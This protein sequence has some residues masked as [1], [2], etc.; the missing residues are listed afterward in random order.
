MWVGVPKRKTGRDPDPGAHS[1]S[2]N[3]SRSDAL[4]LADRRSVKA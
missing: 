3:C 2:P 1:P 4:S